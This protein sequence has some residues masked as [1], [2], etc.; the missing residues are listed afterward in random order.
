M[1]RLKPCITACSGELPHEIIVIR[2]ARSLAEGY[3]RALR[4]ARHDI[5][6]LAHDDVVILS[7]DFAARLMRALSRHDLVGIAG[8]RK[9]AG[10]AWH[11]AGYPHLAG[12][13]GMPGGDGSYVVT[14]YEV[15]E[16]ETK[17]LH[18]LDGLLLA[19][20][21]ETALRLAFDADTFDGW[22]H[23]DLDFS[24]RASQEG[25]DCATCNDVLVV[26]DSQGSYDEQWLKYSQRFIAKHS[27][28][29]GPMQ[30]VFFKPELVSLPLRSAQEWR[31][32]TQHLIGERD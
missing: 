1:R 25:L 28:L 24:L 31:L 2:N 20:R 18:A 23:Y 12:Q 7:P 3:N 21:R 13:V 9:L 11:F 15:A 26:H 32:L 10:D 5:V 27:S 29:I 6:L 14:L 16:R 22:H 8:T 30:S 17:G 19:T 4:L